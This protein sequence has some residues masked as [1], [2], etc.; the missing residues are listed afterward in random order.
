MNNRKFSQD[1]SAGGKTQQ[2]FKASSDVNNIVAHYTATGVDPLADKIGKQKF[3]YATSQ[4]YDE[5][6]RVTAE[7][8]SAFA[9]LPSAERSSF[10][11]SP[12]NW[13]DHMATERLVLD[14]P[15]PPEKPQ[16]P[17]SDDTPTPSSPE[18]TGDP[19]ED[20]ENSKDQAVN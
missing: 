9:H 11:N 18:K 1:F 19:P 10:G 2:H 13:I 4:T 17:V 16:E 5:A 15:P 20:P 12:S 6:M 8:N 14:N 7:I 3:G